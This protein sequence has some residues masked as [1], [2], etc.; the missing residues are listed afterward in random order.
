MR[1]TRTS[2]EVRDPA[3]ANEAYREEQD[4]TQI[5]SEAADAAK[6]YEPEKKANALVWQWPRVGS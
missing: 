6:I 2:E 1:R 4:T 5:Q 3:A